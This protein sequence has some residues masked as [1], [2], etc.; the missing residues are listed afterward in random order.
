V[1]CGTCGLRLER[2]EHDTIMGFALVLFTLVGVV[3]FA[4]LVIAMVSTR[5]TP[6]DFLQ[7]WLPVIALVEVFAF[8]PFAKLLWLAFDL[9]LRPVTP[10]EL[11]W[12]RAATAEFETERDAPTR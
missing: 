9:A 10:S 5:S 6:W 1:K 11:E 3:S 4:I 7:N 2:G 12:H 8:Y